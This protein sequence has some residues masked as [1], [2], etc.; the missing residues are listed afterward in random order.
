[1]SIKS[2]LPTTELNYSKAYDILPLLLSLTPPNRK[3][4]IQLLCGLSFPSPTN[5]YRWQAHNDRAAVGGKIAHA[6]GGFV[7][8]QHR[9]AAFDYAVWWAD[10]HAH[11]THGGRR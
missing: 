5:Q 11:L 2:I 8:D 1:M 4:A 6:C 10:A 3:G 9:G 7:V